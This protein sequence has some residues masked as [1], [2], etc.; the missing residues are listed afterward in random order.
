[1]SKNN[2]AIAILGGMGPEASAK[3]LEVMVSMSATEFGAKN[4]DDF[5]EII[6]DSIP[7][8]DFISSKKNMASALS[9]LRERIKQVNQMKPACFA[10][11]CNTAHVML[12]DLKSASEAPFVSIIDEVAKQL[13]VAG[14][15]TV[16]LLATPVTIKSG[17]YQKVLRSSNIQTIVPTNSQ[18]AQLEAII[19]K[20]IA[21]KINRGDKL[22]LISIAEFL[23]ERSAQGI[24]LGC[25]ELPIIFPK[26]F[27]I[28]TFDSLEILARALLKKFFTDKEVIL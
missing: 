5:P 6:V 3:M 7:I 20:V 28:P 11:A 23:R 25:T 13:K 10:I 2:G 9:I 4:G 18:Q 22:R 12:D 1:M 27:S 26:K 14:L 8:P 16:G 19:R 15:N 21:G 17:L 24:I